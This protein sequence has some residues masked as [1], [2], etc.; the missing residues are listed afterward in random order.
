MRLLQRILLL[1]PLFCTFVFSPLK[2]YSAGFWVIASPLQ[3]QGDGSLTYNPLDSTRYTQAFDI[4]VYR[5]GGTSSPFFLTIASSPSSP[6]RTLESGASS[7][8]YLIYQDAARQQVLK[9]LSDA[10]SASDVYSGTAG[11]DLWP[12]TTATLYVSIDP[13]QFSSSGI[14]QDLLTA[15]VYTGSV[16]SPTLEASTN[17]YFSATVSGQVQA[18]LVDP[19]DPFNASQPSTYNMDFGQA[20]GA[21]SMGVDMRVRSNN[22][23]IIQARSENNQKLVH[24]TLSGTEI[25]YQFSVNSQSVD[26]SSG[27]DIQIASGTGQTSSDGVAIPMTLSVSDVSNKLAGV[28]ED[29]IVFTV[30]E[31]P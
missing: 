25:S 4:T 21:A 24:S 14:Y 15:E 26:L 29:N 16:S 9:S 10:G 12:P 19:G 17:F 2:I 3:W 18:V 22:G 7:L 30:S 31:N 8:N 11:P 13:E 1:L 20:S 28:Y 5:W 6:N 23:Y 27:N